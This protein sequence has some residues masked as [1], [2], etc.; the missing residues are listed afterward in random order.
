M[1]RIAAPAPAPALPTTPAPPA[2]GTM[3][4][5][6]RLD[7]RESFALLDR[8]VALG[9]RWLDTSDNYYFDQDASG[10]GGQSEAVIGRWL[11][12][13]P[14]APVRISTKVGAE[15]NRPG[16]FPDDLEG[17]APDAVDRALSRSLERLG[18]DAVDL[19]WAHI[20]D[21]DVPFTQVVETFGALVADGRVRA[22]GLSN[23]P[24]WRVAE[25]RLHA[26]EAGLAGPSAYQQRFSYLQP[27]PG[28]EV[29]GQPVELGMLGADGLDLLRRDPALTGWVYTPLL[30]GA[31]DRADRPL[32]SEYRHPGNERRM[33]ALAEVA[34]GRGLSRGQVALAWLTGGAPAL[35]PIIGGSRIAQLDE[36]WRGATTVLT[37]EERETLDAAG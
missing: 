26:R 12:A 15:P 19:Y 13:N 34:G 29:E 24:S 6:T 5:G 20:E 17:L 37:A 18:V 30:R 3:H 28:T 33:A 1:A 2:L 11:R 4:M 23:H 32:S 22:W 7:E 25:A 8:F 31:Y 9:G 14:G 35:V 27:L 36:A 10:L 16:G 21:H